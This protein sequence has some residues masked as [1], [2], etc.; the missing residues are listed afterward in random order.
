MFSLCIVN[1]DNRINQLAIPGHV[2]QP[3]DSRGG[4]L[5]AANDVSSQFGVVFMKGG[6][7][8]CPI[9]HS[10]LWLMFQGGYDMFVVSLII[11]SLYGVD[12]NAIVHQGSSYIVLGTQRIGLLQPHLLSKPELNWLFLW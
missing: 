1:G 9:V 6:N 8:V 2:P 11:L 10:N 7:Q 4:F 3:D 5:S 12:G